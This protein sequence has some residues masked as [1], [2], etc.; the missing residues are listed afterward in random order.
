[1]KYSGE[2]QRHGHSQIFLEQR[3]TDLLHVQRKAYGIFLKHPG[4]GML[5]S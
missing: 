4:Y 3:L 2:E 1:M 5:E